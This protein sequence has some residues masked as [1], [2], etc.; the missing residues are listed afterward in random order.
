MALAGTDGGAL[1]LVAQRVRRGAKSALNPARMQSQTGVPP[2]TRGSAGERLLQEAYGTSARAQRFYANQVLDH[3]NEKMRGFIGRQEMMFLSTSD[4][5]GDCDCTFR[6]GPPGFVVVLNDRQLAWPEY[7]G[8]GVM[9][10]LGN[11]SENGHA[12]LLF[13]DF[14]NDI[15]GLHVNGRADVVEDAAIRRL[16]PDLPVDRAPGRRPERWGRVHVEEA[17]I[18]CRKHIPRLS[19]QGRRRGRDADDAQNYFVAGQAPQ[20]PRRWTFWSRKRG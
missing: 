12:G 19:K 18:H 15:V 6:C 3:L 8:N 1:H 16:A 11:I 20:E 5:H 13:L 10:S 2:R 9:A 7:R 17:Y 14:F 4:S